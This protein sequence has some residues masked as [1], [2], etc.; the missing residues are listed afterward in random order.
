MR[1]F[2]EASL[3]RAF[4]RLLVAPPGSV[5]FSEAL[6]KMARFDGAREADFGAEL[7]G[8]GVVL[9]RRG[10]LLGCNNQYFYAGSYTAETDGSIQA[11]IK[12]KHYAGQAHPNFNVGPSVSYIAS[13]HGVMVNN[14]VQL[15]GILTATRKGR[16]RLR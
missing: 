7:G 6:Q 15:N 12:V 16:S 9:L 4:L 3:N 1:T 10:Q 13:L 11:R 8:L 14:R 5:G 2:F